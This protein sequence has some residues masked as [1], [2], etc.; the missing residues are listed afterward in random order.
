MS[1]MPEI[2]VTSGDLANS[3]P[4]PSANPLARAVR[5]AFP[6]AWWVT[7]GLGCVQVC[8]RD[9]GREYQLPDEVQ[10]AMAA[11]RKWPDRTQPFR[12][13]LPDGPA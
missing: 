2:T 11:W 3:R 12:F 7:A 1:S 9:G 5:R 8:D 13:T 6:S 10:A 4:V